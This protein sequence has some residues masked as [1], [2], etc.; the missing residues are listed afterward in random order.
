LN[1]RNPWMS[2]YSRKDRMRLLKILSILF[3]VFPAPLSAPNPSVRF[4]REIPP[5]A[6]VRFLRETSRIPYPT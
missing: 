6:S 1:K 5:P 3:A 4:Y 2:P